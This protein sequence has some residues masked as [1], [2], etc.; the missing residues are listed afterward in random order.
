MRIREA[1][2]DDAVGLARVQVDS[3]RSSYAGIWP[4]AVLE[5]LSYREQ[6]Q[7]WRDWI[8]SNPGDALYVAELVSGEIVGYALARP[9]PTE[10]LGYD[11][12]LIALHVL[13]PYRRQGLGRGLVAAMA[14]ELQSRGSESLMLWVLEENRARGFYQRLGG[15]LLAERKM[16][17]ADRPEVAYGWRRIEVLSGQGRRAEINGQG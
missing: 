3:Y 17:W 10:I 7:D 6:E 4:E 13:G 12:E 5:G 2:I 11:S 9:G 1:M 8:K 15:Q 14:K 16:S